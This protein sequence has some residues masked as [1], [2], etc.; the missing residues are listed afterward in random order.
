MEET[1]FQNLQF[2]KIRNPVN[3]VIFRKEI[4]LIGRATV[5]HAEG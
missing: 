4:G 3:R 1:K 5:L 2:Y